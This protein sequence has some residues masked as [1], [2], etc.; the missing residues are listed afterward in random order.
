[1]T[2]PSIPW[3][4]PAAIPAGT[5]LGLRQQPPAI[6]DGEAIIIDSTNNSAYLGS[7]LTNPPYTGRTLMANNVIFN[8]RKRRG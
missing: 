2:A 3:A 8:K 1:M 4:T 7:G 6:T 5:A